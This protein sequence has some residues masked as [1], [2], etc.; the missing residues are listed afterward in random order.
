MFRLVFLASLGEGLAQ[1]FLEGTQERDLG[2]VQH[3]YIVRH[4]DKYS[5]YPDCSA[6]QDQPCH[7]R[8]LMGDNAYLTPCGVKQAYIRAKSLFAIADDIKQIVASPWART[9]Q[10]ALPLAKHY[11]LKI[12]VERTLSEARQPDEP[13]FAFN[14]LADEETKRQ[15]AEVQKYWDLDYGS[16]P[17]QTP[18]DNALYAE[19]ARLGATILKKRFPPSSG[20]VIVVT[21][22]TPAFSVAYGLCHGDEH[23]P[24]LLEQFVAGQEAIGPGGLI[25]IVRD[26]QGKCLS[27]S[28]TDNSAME[29]SGCG[30]TEG[31]RCDYAN[32]PMWYWPN[33][34]GAGPDTC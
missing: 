1:L 26:A 24:E 31:F 5:S 21:H 2:D 27:M 11:N 22:A 9:L 28:Q 14:A 29:D 3:V 10:T 12:K 18:E 25:H 20:N 32:N 13:N 8:T 34:E 7:N 6:E 19:R 4:G 33:T 23:T 30:A 16:F 17:I 15:L